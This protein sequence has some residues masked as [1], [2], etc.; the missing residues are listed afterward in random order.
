LPRALWMSLNTRYGINLK[1]LVDAVKKY[2]SVDSISNKEKILVYI[3][4]NLLRTIQYNK[5]INNKSFN[6]LTKKNLNSEE[7]KC[8]VDSRIELNKMLLMTPPDTSKKIPSKKKRQKVPNFVFDLNQDLNRNKAHQ[9][10][11]KPKIKT[12]LKQNISNK[13]SSLSRKKHYDEALE[14]KPYYLNVKKR[15]N[16]KSDHETDGS[17]SETINSSYARVNPEPP[18]V[19]DCQTAKNKYS[20]IKANESPLNILKSRITEISK[21]HAF[22]FLSTG[23][24]VNYSSEDLNSSTE[25]NS[26]GMINYRIKAAA[27]KSSIYL[28][29]NT[30]LKELLESEQKN[31]PANKTTNQLESSSGCCSLN[32][33]L[34]NLSENYL[35][36]LYLFVKIFYLLSTIGQFLLL[37]R[38]I[39]N[40]YE[41]IGIDLVKSFFYET[42]WP[43]LAVFPRMTLCEIYIREIGV[44]HPY[45]IQCVLSINL[46]NEVIFICVWFWLLFLVVLISID[47]FVRFIYNLLSCSNCKR[48]LFT[49]KYLELIHMSETKLINKRFST[50]L[51][52][53]TLEESIKNHNN[54]IYLNVEKYSHLFNKGI[55]SEIDYQDLTNYESKKYNIKSKNVLLVASK[56]EE[57]EL[58]EKFCRNFNNDTLFAL[59]IIRQNASSLIVS[60]IIEHLW[61][62]F[63]RINF[64]FSNETNDYFLKKIIFVNN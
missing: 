45:L 7:K 59:S 29:N 54:Y 60:E 30:H 49:L 17:L 33:L 44:V 23:Y 48:K 10:N 55:E 51:N 62:Q 42:E 25:T 24:D 28:I 12:K 16:F 58:F 57:H 41:M 63:K 35:T 14:T 36:R 52:E 9:T 53:K 8:Y 50:I 40:G 21:K 13:K 46:F 61:T 27:K 1:N 5:Y 20:N 34:P 39:G 56:D 47:L 43:H 32:C 31:A 2:E 18:P 19:A 3:C 6:F 38:L 4:K 22:N 26:D 15:V 37:S 11:L 64:V